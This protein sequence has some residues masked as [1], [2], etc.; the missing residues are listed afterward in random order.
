M[1]TFHFDG[2]TVVVVI[3]E[4]TG[5]IEDELGGAIVFFESNDFGFGVSTGEVE[6]ILKRGTLETV[7]AL[8][9]VA[10][11]E[12]VGGVAPVGSEEI[13]DLVLG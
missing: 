12:D 11:Y 7:D 8:L 10:D 3:N 4:V 5:G 2:E 9:V 6:G 1:K 13:D